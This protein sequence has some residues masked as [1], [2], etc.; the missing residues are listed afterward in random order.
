M[1]LGYNLTEQEFDLE[2]AR[3]TAEI[4]SEPNLNDLNFTSYA[5]KNC[6]TEKGFWMQLVKGYEKHFINSP[7]PLVEYVPLN[8][9]ETIEL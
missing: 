8:N 1:E 4:K 9:E 2:N 7:Y 6:P 5:T 3:V